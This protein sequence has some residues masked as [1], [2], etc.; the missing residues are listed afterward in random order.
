MLL[1]AL[2]LPAGQEFSAPE[3]LLTSGKC[4]LCRWL[5]ASCAGMTSSILT[6]SQE[7]N[8]SDGDFFSGEPSIFFIILYYY[9][10]ESQRVNSSSR[11][12]L[13][14]KSLIH[15]PATPPV[16]STP[17][18]WHIISSCHRSDSS[19]LYLKESPISTLK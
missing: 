1:V 18:T 13:P 4:V 15:F 7:K 6:A 10:G 3:E 8:V 17:A 9:L 12:H 11:Q 5:F 16:T 14:I 2:W 19:N